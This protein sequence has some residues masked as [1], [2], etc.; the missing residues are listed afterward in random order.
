MEVALEGAHALAAAPDGALWAA[1]NDGLARVAPDGTLTRYDVPA[2]QL[3]IGADVWFTTADAVCRLGGE[4]IPA[5]APEGLAIGP[6]GAVWF[7][8]ADAVVRE[9]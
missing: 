3:A 7:T 8:T 1:L 6:D 4:V 9:G 5:E 2:R